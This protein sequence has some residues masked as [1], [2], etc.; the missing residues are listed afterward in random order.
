M[1]RQPCRLHRAFGSLSGPQLP[2]E[3]VK[4][5][6][7]YILIERAQQK[8]LGG[9]ERDGHLCTSA[10][11]KWLHGATA[12]HIG[13]RPRR[14]TVVRSED[15]WRTQPERRKISAFTPYCGGLVPPD[16]CPK[17]LISLLERDKHVQ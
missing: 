2:G 10:E 16:S 3:G 7:V 17:L 4:N 14:T 13:G 6:R 1:L 15:R 5:C 12:V 9:S 11:G 8:E